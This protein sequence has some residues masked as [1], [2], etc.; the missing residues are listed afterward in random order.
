VTLRVKAKRLKTVLR[1]GLSLRLT[2]TEDAS[3]TITLT[4]SRA[5]ARALGLKRKP[6]RPVRVGGASAALRTGDSTVAVTLTAKARKAMRA[7][8]RVKLLVT[9]VISDAAGNRATRT[10]TVTLKR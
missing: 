10:L 7:A 6:R 1:N 8:R 3:A 4:V 9:V 5:T 2:A